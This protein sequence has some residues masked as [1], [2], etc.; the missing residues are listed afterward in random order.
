[1]DS[2]IVDRANL[3]PPAI[4]TLPDALVLFQERISSRKLNEV[5]L[6]GKRVGCVFIKDGTNEKFLVLYKR[7]K[8]L[9]FGKHFPKVPDGG[10]AIITSMKLV[11]WCAMEDIK[12][13][14]IFPDGSAYWAD[15]M[16]FWKF[17]EKWDTEHPYIPG[18]I[19]LPF[20]MWN[21]LW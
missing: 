21:R 5:T 1:M 3:E 8:Y 2:Q 10:Q 4:G 16:E 12:L 14:T 6:N 11:H 13:V 20:R 9:Y 15:A 18:E 7:E 17:Y 19:A